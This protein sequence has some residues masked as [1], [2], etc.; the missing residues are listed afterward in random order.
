M[1]VWLQNPLQ[2]SLDHRLSDSV[3]DC[4]NSQRTRFSRI[5]FRDV[6]STHGRREVASGTHPIPDSIEIVAQLFVEFLDSLSVNPCR[7]SVRLHLLVR[8]PH[9]A[10]RNTERLGFIHAGPPLLGCPLDKAE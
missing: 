6:N 8:F 9:L 1:K 4:R 7:P 3:G 5:A 10:F 2:V